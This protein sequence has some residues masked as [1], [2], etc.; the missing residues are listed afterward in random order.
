MT[1]YSVVTTFS[2]DGFKQYGKRF[3]QTFFQYWPVNV[4]LFVFH[5]GLAHADLKDFGH[6]RRVTRFLNLE[7]TSSYIRSFKAD[8]KDDAYAHGRAVAPGSRWKPSDINKGYNFRFDAVRFCHKPFAIDAALNSCDVGDV[9]F[10]IDADVYTKSAI[11]QQDIN[12]YLPVGFDVSYL[13]RVG[14]HSECG[15]MGFRLPA[16][17]AML[18]SITQQYVRG[19]LFKLNEWHDSHVFDVERDRHNYL[20]FHD[21]S[22]KLRQ[23][24]DVFNTSFLGHK[25]CHLKGDRKLTGEWVV[26]CIK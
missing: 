16:A 11:T 5:E 6:T 1:K 13:G 23:T 17:R 22:S 8:L 3:L 12:R 24:G 21:L 14:T 4:S 2:N 10:W 15:F 7:N 25:L 18:D 9:M 19:S 26:E 20:K